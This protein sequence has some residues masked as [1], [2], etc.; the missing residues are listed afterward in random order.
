MSPQNL[1]ITTISLYLSSHYRF[2]ATNTVCLKILQALDGLKIKRLQECHLKAFIKILGNLAVMAAA[3][4][5][6]WLCVAIFR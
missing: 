1:P 3:A 4:V 6:P 2:L 5:D